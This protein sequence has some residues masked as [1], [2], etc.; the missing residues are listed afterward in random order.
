M[1]CLILLRQQI[2]RLHEKEEEEP[3]ITVGE[4]TTTTTNTKAIHPPPITETVEA[5]MAVE[6]VTTTTKQISKTNN[7][8]VGDMEARMAIETT[9]IK[10]MVD[11]PIETTTII[12]Q[13]EANTTTTTTGTAG[14]TTEAITKVGTM[15][16]EEDIAA[17][18]IEAEAVAEAV[19]ITLME[20][21]GAEEVAMATEAAVTNVARGQETTTMTAIAGDRYF[22][23]EIY[24][25]VYHCVITNIR[26][27]S[28]LHTHREINRYP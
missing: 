6:V 19:E 8:T 1:R 2:R 26:P 21:G 4:T 13:E 27:F 5:V 7:N 10:I 17:A 23:Q 9:G 18:A 24:N 14:T 16:A 25:S 3:I 28:S 11:T 22:S 12:I 20:R 15:A